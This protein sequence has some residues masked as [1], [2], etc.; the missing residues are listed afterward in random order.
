MRVPP[1]KRS[2]R[3]ASGARVPHVAWT[4]PNWAFGVVWSVL[5]TLIAL[6][7]WLVWLER[8]RADTR[9]ALSC[10]VAQFVLNALWPPVFFAGYLV[11]GLPALWIGLV[12]ILLLDLL[13]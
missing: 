4:P 7:G 11:V 10:Y 3:Q 9:V 6:A 2:V 5:Y 1:R 12:I 8:R 13:V